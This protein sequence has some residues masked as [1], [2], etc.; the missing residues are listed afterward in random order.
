MHR[1]DPAWINWDVGRVEWLPDQQTLHY[2]TEATGYAHLYVTHV[3]SGAT[4]QLTRG[5]FVV[6]D[7]QAGLDGKYLYYKANANHPGVYEAYRVE[8]ASGA[9]EQLTQLGGMNDFEVSPDQQHLLVTHSTAMSP[10]ELWVQPLAK[11]EPARQITL[12]VSAEFQQLPWVEPKFVTVPSRTG[13][14]IHARLYLPPKRDPA[15][16]FPRSSSFMAPGTC[17]TRIK[18]GPVTFASSCSIVCWRIAASLCWTWIIARRRDTVAIGE[19]PSIAIWA[20]RKW[21]IWRTALPG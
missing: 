11:A 10:P 4:R 20:A 5:E 6:S 13:R 14:P 3:P 17:R 7:V 8:A 15:R 9:I 19:R 2:L 18:D 12:T 21:R 16:G 1:R